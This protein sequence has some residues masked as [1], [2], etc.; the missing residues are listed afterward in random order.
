MSPM[1]NVVDMQG[2]PLQAPPGSAIGTLGRLAL[3]KLR[4]A[5][6]EVLVK[7]DDTLFDLMQSS[8][9]TSETQAL[10]DAMRAIRLNRPAI[11]G[12]FEKSLRDALVALELGSP[13]VAGEQR[14]PGGRTELSLV[15]EGDLEEQLGTQTL[16]ENLA[17]RTGADYE[18]LTARLASFCPSVDFTSRHNP[19]GPEHIAEAIRSGLK[20]I[21][22]SAR[23]RLILFKL[24]ERGI[25]L[26]LGPLHSELNRILGDA[27]VPARSLGGGGAPRQAQP[28]AEPSS[29]PEAR[30]READANADDLTGGAIAGEGLSSEDIEL[31]RTLQQLLRQQRSATGPRAPLPPGV[32]PMAQQEM[33]SVLSLFQAQPPDTL[34]NAL[35][36]EGESLAERLKRELLAGAIRLGVAPEGARVS[37]ADEDTLDLVG[38]LFEVLLSERVLQDKLRGTLSRLVVPYTKAALMDRRM[39]LQKSHPA[40]KLLNSLAE[41]SESVTGDTPADREVQAKVEGTVDRLVVEFNE[42]VAIFQELEQEFRNFIDQYRKRMELAERRAAEAQRGKE[43]LDQARAMAAAEIAVRLGQLVPPPLVEEVLRR[44]WS[45][46]LSVTWLRQGDGSEAYQKAL[47]LGD[48]VI[49]SVVAAKYGS[50]NYEGARAPLRAALLTM[51]GSSGVAGE[52]AD[53]IADAVDATLMA[54][55][56]GA[57]LP[58][59]DAAASSVMAAS[60]A[61]DEPPPA[62]PFAAMME[63][64]EMSTASPEM[65]KRAEAIEQGNWV[66]LATESGQYEPAKLSWVSPI[67]GRRLFVNRRGLK[68]ACA[69]TEELAQMLTDGRL[70]IREADTAFE[71]AMHQVLGK[72]QDSTRPPPTL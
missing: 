43:R 39:F 59:I 33:L 14:K 5:L 16:A 17:R 34:M 67:S 4:K 3:P 1:P 20:Q 11:E 15:G 32:Q 31:V 35:T 65:L 46:H 63:G 10:I 71:R 13:D 52:A 40:R 60:V 12:E 38:M 19:I 58:E 50:R 69:S 70:V 49:Q 37:A 30:R 44:Y 6:S 22:I 55:A 25:V 2:R 68:V 51:L 45:H 57:A 62:D 61:Q 24:V 56:V 28:A 27:G 54:L 26:I 23:V 72:L 9:G 42:D 64:W 66:E 53:Q 29:E 21:D 7:A 48:V 36:D 41:A 8:T 18:H 47:N